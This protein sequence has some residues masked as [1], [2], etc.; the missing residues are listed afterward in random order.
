MKHI[1]YGGDA[2]TEKM[3]FRGEAVLGQG[4]KDRKSKG[5]Y[6]YFATSE[7][8]CLEVIFKQVFKI[9]ILF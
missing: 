1:I 5:D 2:G 4:G 8:S 6:F 3:I 7:K 9:C